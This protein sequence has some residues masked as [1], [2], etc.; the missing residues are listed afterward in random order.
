MRKKPENVLHNALMTQRPPSLAFTGAGM[1]V[2][3]LLDSSIEKHIQD[4]TLRSTVIQTA[5]TWTRHR[6]ENLLTKIIPSKLS[7]SAIKSEKAKAFDLLDALSRSGSLPIAF[8]ELHVI[9]CVTHCFEKNV[10]NTLIQDNINPIEKLEMS[11]LLV[12][13]TIHGKPAGLLLNNDQDRKR[14]TAN[15]ASIMAEDADSG[16]A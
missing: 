2:P 11:T 6:Q 5:P 10:M 15:F 13:S 4:S 8:S 16:S 9:A 7:A 1:E 14:L 12:A 3:K